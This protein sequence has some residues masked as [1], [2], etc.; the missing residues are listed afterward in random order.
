MTSKEALESIVE[1]Y[2]NSVIERYYKSD[3][4]KFRRDELYEIYDNRFEVVKQ[5]LERL[6]K[7]E[8]ALKIIINKN[9]NA[10]LFVECLE[11]HKEKYKK[12]MSFKEIGFRLC[13]ASNLTKKEFELLK[14]VLC[15]A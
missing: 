14:E 1:D 15:N 3:M 13:F 10:K 4:P 2:H 7:L 5:E 11:N 8:K 9:L 6:E 12:E